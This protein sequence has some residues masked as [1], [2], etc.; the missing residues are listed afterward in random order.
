MITKKIGWIGCGNMG[1]AI[2][3]GALE[4]GVISKDDA[5]VYDIKEEMMDK[6][7]GWGAALGESDADVCGK[8]DIVLLAVKPQ[9]AKEALAQCG[10]ALDGKALIS[11]VAGV[12]VERLRG[13]ISGNARILRVMPNTP[14]M[15]FEGAFAL[16]ADNDFASEEMAAAEELFRSI[17]VVE[18]VPETLIDAV[19]GLSGGGPAYVAMFIEAMADGGVKQGLPRATAYRLAAQTCLGTAKMILDM[20]IHPGQLK[21][22]VTSPGGT[23]IEGCEALEKGGMRGT[24]IECINVATEKSKQL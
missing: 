17:G 2:L 10:E 19:C 11:I 15:V 14:A 21:D 24:V 18:K 4:S 8:C 12:T 23:T 16:C 3:H 20:D 6:A 5:I 9:Q 13:M 1:G 7:K 22:M